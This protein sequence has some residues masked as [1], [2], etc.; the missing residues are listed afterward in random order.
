MKNVSETAPALAVIAPGP[1][2]TLQDL[3]RAGWQRLGIPVSGA[4]DPVALAAANLLVGNP[5]ETGALEIS[6]L[7]PTLRVEA[8]SVRIAYAG[9]AT[10]LELFSSSSSSD[11]GAPARRLP[12]LASVRLVRGQT[13]RIGGL[14][15]STVGYLAVEGGF[16]VTPFLGSTSTLPRAALGGFSGRPI[17]AGDCLALAAADAPE[18]TELTLRT[19]DLAAPERCRVMLG[20]QADHFTPEG[21]ETFLSTPWVVSPA[22]DRMGM[23]LEGPAIAHRGTVD[24]VTDGIAPGTVQVPG[25]GLPIVLL[26]D[27]QTTGGYAKIATVVSA[28]L[29]R[30]GRLAPGA[31]VRFERVDRT[32]A[33]AARRA[34]IATIDGLKERLVEAAPADLA[35]RLSSVNL[36]G[37]FLDMCAGPEES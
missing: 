35:A 4:L 36:I 25:S 3:G 11:P 14:T 20:P 8:E 10:S 24:I 30:L 34:L 37:G 7:G 5:P 1:R 19:L 27:R 21:I 12:P 29:P 15:G 17:A 13:I 6:F 18:R 26:A 33:V 23:R 32:A 2:T 22:T 9:G 31:T 28:D 16:A